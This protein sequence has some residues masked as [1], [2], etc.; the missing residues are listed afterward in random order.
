[1]NRLLVVYY[2]SLTFLQSPKVL[3]LQERAPD[4]PSGPAETFRSA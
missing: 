4:D 3:S 1:M 2:L